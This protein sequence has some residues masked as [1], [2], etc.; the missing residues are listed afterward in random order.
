[1]QLPLFSNTYD[2]ATDFEI[3]DL[4]FF[5]LNKKYHKLH[6]KLYL[7]AKNSFVGEVTFSKKNIKKLENLPPEKGRMN[8]PTVILVLYF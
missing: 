5:F 6:I 4:T 1:M 3:C 7:I 8:L 2:G